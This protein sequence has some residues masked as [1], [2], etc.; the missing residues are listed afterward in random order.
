MVHEV[1]ATPAALGPVGTGG[2]GRREQLTKPVG[3]LN[4]AY[5]L[6][7]LSHAGYCEQQFAQQALGH[8]LNAFGLA[9]H[10][11][12]KAAADLLMRDDRGRSRSCKTLH[13]THRCPP[14]SARFSWLSS[15]DGRDRIAH[16]AHTLR[17]VNAT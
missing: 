4:L 9:F 8:T 1:R 17:H 13:E 2:T 10:L 7:G 15:L 3:L 14:E 16:Q 12:V 5:A 11:Q 6:A